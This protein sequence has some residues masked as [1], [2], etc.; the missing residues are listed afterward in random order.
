MTGPPESRKRSHG[1]LIVHSARIFLRKSIVGNSKVKNWMVLLLIAI[2]FGST[3]SYY[4]LIGGGHPIQSKV[5]LVTKEQITQIMGGRWE[6][7]PF[8]VNATNP[9]TNF[10]KQYS[11]GI[12]NLTWEYLDSELIGN[13]SASNIDVVVVQYNSTNNA[14]NLFQHLMNSLN[15]HSSQV[16]TV[17]GG[18]YA[19]FQGVIG[20]LTEEFGQRSNFIVIIMPTNLTLSLTQGKQIISDQFNEL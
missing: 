9:L 8:A 14:S 15:L 5:T 4:V 3:I 11:V 7:E 13:Y 2:L 6:V 12:T 18:K 19:Y 1:K 17:S 10:G 20:S 16:N